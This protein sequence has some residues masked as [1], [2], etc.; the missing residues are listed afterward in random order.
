MVAVALNYFA[1]KPIHQDSLNAADVAPRWQLNVSDPVNLL[2]ESQS[3][4]RRSYRAA[5]VLELGC[6]DVE[7]RLDAVS[8]DPTH[9]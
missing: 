7:V 3:E 9:A 6:P 8:E 5:R 4:R 1:Y 2:I